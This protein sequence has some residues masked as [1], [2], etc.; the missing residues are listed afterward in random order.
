MAL[1]GG[2]KAFAAAPF[3]P[4]PG[5]QQLLCAQIDVPLDRSGSV[6]G[7]VSLL[8][9]ELPAD[10]TP[11]GVLLLLA[12][13]PGQSGTDAFGLS[14]PS[15][16]QLFRVAFPG[17]TL[18]TLDVRGTGKSGALR[19][20]ALQN[21]L[22]L[23]VEQEATLTAQ[24][25][26][27]LGPS[28]RFYGTR[29]QAED[30]DAARQ[31]LGAN[32]I[33]VMGVSYGTQLAL[34]YAELHPANVERLILDSVAPPEGR[35]PFSLDVIR[36]L[37]ATLASYCA[38]GLCRGVTGNFPGELAAL[39]NA[40]EAKPLRGSVLTGRGR[41]TVTMNGEDLLGLTIDAD[42]NPAVQAELPAAVHAARAGN[43]L[44]L[45]RLFYLDSATQ[46][47]PADSISIGQFVSTLCTDGPFP[48][49]AGTPVAARAA[50]ISSTIAALAPGTFGP[51]GSWAAH[52]GT[53]SLC[54]LWPDA[55][56]T[57]LPSAALPDVPVL[58]LTGGLDLR[59]PAANAAAVTGRFP[60]GRLLVVPGVGHSVLT[61]DLSF[62]AVKSVRLWLAGGTPPSRCPRVAPLV[63]PIPAFSK[64][65]GSTR[66]SRAATL[67]TAKKVIR[68]AEASVLFA[69][70]TPSGI[71]SV[72]GLYG[73]MVVDSGTTVRLVQYTDVPGLSLDGTLTIVSGAGPPLRF[74]GTVSVSGP[75]ATPLTFSI[76]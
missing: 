58:T 40:I 28:R 44:P 60:H 2:G 43:A 3:A 21:A 51:F 69:L 30:I 76:A 63:A 27:S 70:F 7:T 24:C 12:G 72:P 67:A 15:S 75:R 42:L 56:G 38:G 19:C 14:S 47:E 74:K 53:A 29:D 62:C 50:A 8:V 57:T 4:C 20:P 39:A 5:S 6:P 55:L 41:R 26:A 10:G 31:A 34:T 36:S 73:G 22:F 64:P 52:L 37:P 45:L 46:A 71:G 68:E 32:Q 35:D 65:A 25:A 23:T 17:Y 33:A 16:T 66:L 49:A 54:Q 48:W 11:R 18:A 59:T 13:G 1:F 61:A 9:Q